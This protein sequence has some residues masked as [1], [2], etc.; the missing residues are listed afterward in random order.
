M[1]E[2]AWSDPWTRD[3]WVFVNGKMVYADKNVFDSEEARITPDGLYSIEN[4][5]FLWSSSMP[6]GGGT[7][8]LLR[9][10]AKR[11]PEPAQSRGPLK[12][13]AAASSANVRNIGPVLTGQ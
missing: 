3:V 13:M 10:R 6:L 5:S 8:K 9:V 1:G 4:D 12:R 2:L 7:A 11:L